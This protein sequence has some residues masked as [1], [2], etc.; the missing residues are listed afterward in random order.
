[1]NLLRESPTPVV[2]NP[3]SHLLTQSTV[4]KFHRRPR[5]SDIVNSIQGA[6][7]RK[8]PELESK[9]KTLSKP[10]IQVAG[11][12]EVNL[13]LNSDNP[14]KYLLRDK[15][16]GQIAFAF[17]VMHCW[18]LQKDL[19]DKEDKEAFVKQC[20]KWWTEL[21]TLYRRSYWAKELEYIR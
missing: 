21:P 3:V 1:M 8:L 14:F 7:C 19:Y 18:E 13:D 16:Q 20:S 5:K 9:S 4:P 10:M 2:L 11:A 15:E 6:P 12:E 17:Y